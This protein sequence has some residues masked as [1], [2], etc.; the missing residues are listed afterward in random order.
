MSQSDGAAALCSRLT[1]LG[2][3]CHKTVRLYGEE[4]ELTSDPSPDGDGFSVEGIA[5]SSGKLTRMR[6]PRPVIQVV[7]RELEAARTRIA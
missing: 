2:Y 7:T 4:L 5:R 1:A 6:L 3:A